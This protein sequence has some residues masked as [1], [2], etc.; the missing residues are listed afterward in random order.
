M[1]CPLLHVSQR[2]VDAE[3]PSDMR[4]VDAGKI[5]ED[6]VPDEGSV[7]VYRQGP[8]HRELPM[9]SVDR[10]GINGLVSVVGPAEGFLPARAVLEDEEMSASQ[11]MVPR[12]RQL[13]RKNRATERGLVV[14][15][16][17]G[18]GA[19]ATSI[20]N[21]SRSRRAISSL[22]GYPW[23]M[24]NTTV[25]SNIGSSARSSI[26][27]G[28]SSASSSGSRRGERSRISASMLGSSL[29]H[30][31]KRKSMYSRMEMRSCGAISA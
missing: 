4:H 12:P 25:G 7:L 1:L 13:A 24:S 3:L 20:P 26:T 21:R 2:E 14:E 27:L 17:P 18:A 15:L 22:P 5:C 10:S 28:S 6:H 16:E 29:A 23:V 30:A 19:W 11:D 9:S 31:R 8:P